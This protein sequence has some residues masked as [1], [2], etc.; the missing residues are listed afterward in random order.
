MFFHP[1][2]LVSADDPK[3]L[4]E[5]FPST[6]DYLRRN[7]DYLA[8]RENGRFAGADWHQYGRSQNID[9]MLLPKILVP[10]IAD[11]ASFALDET[12]HDRKLMGHARSADANFIGAR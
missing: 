1:R 3:Q 7:Q 12:G 2:G 4:R 10:D 9:L 5:K 6:W 11:R 8:A